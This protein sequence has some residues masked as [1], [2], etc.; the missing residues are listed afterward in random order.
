MAK[1]TI[2]IPCYNQGEYL[3]EAIESAYSQTMQAHEIIICNDGS[4][5][6]TQ[7]IAERYMFKQFPYI[8]SPVRVINQVNKGLPSARNSI[9]MASTGEYI[10]F[11]DA[12][13]VLMENAVE[14]I[15]NEINAMHAD[16]VAPSFIEF[17]KSDRQVILQTFNLEDLKVA[18]RIAYCQAI[19]RSVLV[20]CGGYNPKMI[21]GWEDFDLT[22]DLLKRGKT[23][24]LI[25]EPLFKYRVKE[26]SMITEANQH[27]DELWNQ[28]KKNHPTLFN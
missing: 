6:D 17:G 21:W 13:D 26:R 3:E 4:T 27:A 11:L 22:F 23:I 2:G 16:I 24:S 28:I 15:E 8:D 7:E 5:D 10:L 19:K 18:N 12:D 14:R 9:I 20:E 25:Q 1:I